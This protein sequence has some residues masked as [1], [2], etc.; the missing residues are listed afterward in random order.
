[1]KNAET[2][3]PKEIRDGIAN[4]KDFPAVTGKITIDENRNASKPAVIL[5]IKDGKF[6]YKSLV[7]P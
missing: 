5:E 6:L 1:M 7:D 4:T 3:S 2:V